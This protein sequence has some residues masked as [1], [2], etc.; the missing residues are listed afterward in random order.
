MR[1]FVLKPLILIVVAL[2][3][4][5]CAVLPVFEEVDLEEQQDAPVVRHALANLPF[6]DHWTMLF[7]NGAEAGFTHLRVIAGATPND[8]TLRSEAYLQMFLLGTKTTVIITATDWVDANLR[9]KRYRYVYTIDGAKKRVDGT[10]EEGVLHASVTGDAGHRELDIAL[11]RPIYPSRAV[12]LYPIIDGLER[13]KSYSFVTYDGETQILKAVT[14]RVDGYGA[15]DQFDGYAYSLSSNVSGSASN[16]WIDQLGRCVLEVSMK[17]IFLAK[18]LAAEKAREMLVSAAFNHTP[19]YLDYTTIRTEQ[20]IESARDVKAMRVELSSLGEA[21]V[22]PD[23]DRQRCWHESDVYA[24]QIVASPGHI[25]KVAFEEVDIKAMFPSTAITSDAPAVV[26]IASDIAGE[27]DEQGL[28]LIHSL[29]DWILSRVR[30]ST[31]PIENASQALG[32][33]HQSGPLGRTY[34][35]AAL[36]RAVG[37]PTR[38]VN[39]LVYSQLDEGFIY[40]SW[41]ESWIDGIWYRV[42]PAFG[43]LSDDATHIKL[44]LGD[45]DE[46]LSKF[47]DIIGRL[48]VNVLAYD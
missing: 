10:I 35:F 22:L 16:I 37:I 29:N 13:G 5:G 38:I 36:A 33:N 24:C 4:A 47:A 18:Q 9:H 31:E 12:C 8:F 15:S 26:S 44:G 48:S 27:I 6:T 25:D 17:G 41:A 7:L 45:T 46:E 28:G 1:V 11:K 21:W 30:H 42:D 23:D 19:F 3:I 20:P 34:L 32:S 2:V 39:G 43:G 14:Q 40:H